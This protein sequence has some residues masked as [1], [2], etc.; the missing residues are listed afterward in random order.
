MTASLGAR[1]RADSCRAICSWRLRSC[2]CTSVI[3]SR[4]VS[5]SCCSKKSTVAAAKALTRSAA[6]LPSGSAVEIVKVAVS[7]LAAVVTSDAST[8]ASPE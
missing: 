3:W 5:W 1:A 8:W 7:A 6:V 4:A 2:R